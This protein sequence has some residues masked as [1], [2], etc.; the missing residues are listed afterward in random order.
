MNIMENKQ[1]KKYVRYKDG[2]E[3]YG[4]GITS[5]MRLAKRQR[6]FIRFVILH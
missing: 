4:M 1:K 5:F 2:A 3:M 6:P